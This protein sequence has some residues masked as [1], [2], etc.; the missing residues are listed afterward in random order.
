MKG[1]R[2]FFFV[3]LAVATIILW[4]IFRRIDLQEVLH[5]FKQIKLTVLAILVITAALKLYIQY[6]NWRYC[7]SINKEYQ[8]KRYEVVK[9][10]FIGTALRFL[11]P[12]GHGTFGKAYYLSNDKK[13]SLVSVGIEKVLQTWIALLSGSFAA[14]FFFQKYSLTLRLTV[15]I[16]AGILPWLFYFASKIFKNHQ[17]ESYST[18]YRKIIL[19][20]AGQQAIFILLTVVQYYV[21]ISQFFRINFIDTL[22]AVPLILLGNVI[23]I[24]YAGLGV[25]ESFAI[26]LLGHYNISSEVAVTTS[27]LVFLLNSVLPALGGVW[28]IVSAKKESNS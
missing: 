11:I 5:S 2:L 22:I 4:L 18:N 25:R 1:K 19:P 27:L 16:V 3:K 14:A 21:L 6:L 24:S 9:S 10:F 28:L 26:H 17:V 12:G 20:I 7:L 13:A 8:P 15:I 23:P